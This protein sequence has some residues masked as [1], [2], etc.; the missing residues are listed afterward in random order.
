MTTKRRTSLSL[1][2]AAL[3]ALAVAP[4]AE[5]AGPSCSASAL[6]AAV[7]GQPAVE[8]VVAGA[9]GGC[10]TAAAEG[11][12]LGGGLQAATAVARTALTDGGR[13]AGAI[14]AVE[15]L[16]VGGLP[17]LPLDL[18]A[19]Q[20]PAGLDAVPV[21]L[22]A[23]A[24]LL[25]LPPSIVV[26]ATEA[27]RRMVPERRL[28]A[29]DLLAADLVQAAAGARCQDGAL[30]VLGDTVVEGLRALGR[31]LADG[32]PTDLAV[33]LLEPLA[34]P[35]SGIDTAD[36][37]LPAG[38]SFGAPVVG[39]VLEAAVRQALAALPPVRVPATVARVE[40]RPGSPAASPTATAQRAMHVRVTAL[41]RT[42]LDAEL[43]LAAVDGAGID[44]APPTPVAAQA[45][46]SPQ[47]AA[48]ACTTRRLTL[49]DVVRRGRQVVLTGAADREL[50][51]QTV[52]LVFEA[53]GRTVAEAVV[54][55]DGAFRA[56]APL[57]AGDLRSSNRARYRAVARGE[58]SLNLK[59]QRRMRLTRLVTARDGRVVLT[60]VV[61]G[62]LAEGGT[63][64]I[65]R[66]I[67]CTKEVVVETVRA[68]RGGR[69]RAVLP[70]P[71]AGQ[72]GVYRAAATVLVGERRKPFPTFTLPGYVEQ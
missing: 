51:G 43:G 10:R 60:G 52:D 67:S 1:G 64:T 28:P 65:R 7:L 8:P 41:G 62:R 5:A 11:S 9:E 12:G 45:P 66:R 44:C 47:E 63:V 70:A 69:F 53:T 4:A 56:V 68:G 3:A 40:A 26:D 20:L 34:L 39:P 55:P 23:S 59:L 61:D 14:A 17:E 72:A 57:P 32:A 38:L 6:R 24:A 15:D 71:P 21:P 13:A 48:L 18:P 58:R 22:P 2:T 35:L 42:L 27:A 19:A 49:V 31:P 54:G 25:G 37:R 36:V 29:L 30:Q 50:A 33:E 46:P 16:R